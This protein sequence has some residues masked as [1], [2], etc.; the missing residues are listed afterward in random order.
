MYRNEVLTLP[1]VESGTIC[2]VVDFS[3]NYV[4]KGYINEN[5][6][7]TVR[8]LS[9]SPK[10]IDEKFF[11]DK[12]EKA[13]EKRKTFDGAFRLAH[14]EADGLPGL[15]VDIYGKYA[16]V[17]INTVGMEKMKKLL[18]G[19]LQKVMNLEGI[20]EK[21]DTSARRREGL[22]N[23]IGWVKGKGETL[24]PFKIDGVA[25]FSD[26]DGQ[27]TGFFLDQRFNVK[28]VRNFSNGNVLDTFCYT[29]EFSLNAFKGGADHVISIDASKR[30]K[31]VY[32]KHL[33][34]NNVRSGYEFIV[35]NVFDKLREFERGGK[36]FD[37]VILDPPAFAKSVKHLKTAV[38]GYKE[39]NLRAMKLLKNGGY[40]VTS[41]CSAALSRGNFLKIVEDAAKDAR[42]SLRC[43]YF[44]VQ[45]YD[46]PLMIGI[47]KSEY[48]KFFVFEVEAIL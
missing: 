14:S 19:A 28:A 37:T 32:E 13:L 30:A 12:L 40:L 24:L 6:F 31:E 20:F 25:Y 11:I 44:G 35:G 41:S 15:I 9:H 39:I 16:V 21:S 5:S 18:L 33:A 38:R 23:S 3:N 8:L 27:K 10:K 22:K 43:V 4:G 48:L 29:G 2:D 7:I 34:M 36:R 46:H 26:L 1:E 47:E 45:S 42:K 17:Q